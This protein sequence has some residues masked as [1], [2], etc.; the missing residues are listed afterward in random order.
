MSI[1]QAFVG[2]VAIL[3]G[4]LCA[5]VGLFEFSWFFRLPKARWFE[6]RWGRR[7]TRILF[8]LLGLAL[9]LLGCYI[10]MGIPPS[11]ASIEEDGRQETTYLDLLTG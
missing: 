6:A 1:E 9:I 5:A 8:G 4:A 11:Q 7:A 10:A 3:L 2:S